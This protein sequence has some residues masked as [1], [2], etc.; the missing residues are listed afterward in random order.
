MADSPW[1]KVLCALCLFGAMSH[2]KTIKSI[3][4]DAVE[5]DST[6]RIF[7]IPNSATPQVVAIEPMAFNTLDSAIPAPTIVH[8]RESSYTSYWTSQNMSA[9]LFDSQNAVSACCLRDRLLTAYTFTFAN[10]SGTIEYQY[11]DGG[12]PFSNLEGTHTLVC[13]ISTG[14]FHMSFPWNPTD[15]IVYANQSDSI[16]IVN[17]QASSSVDAPANTGVHGLTISNSSLRLDRSDRL[18]AEITL[19]DL[20]GKALRRFD[21]MGTQSASLADLDIGVYICVVKI[22]DIPTKTFRYLKTR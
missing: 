11:L 22:R 17:S 20:R 16:V 13:A 9:S 15:R 5:Q 1:L 4:V 2:G 21:L 12:C 6:L 8:L 18:H 14:K 10:D 7:R 19:R 3:R